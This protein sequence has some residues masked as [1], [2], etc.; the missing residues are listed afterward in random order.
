MEPEEVPRKYLIESERSSECIT[1]LYRGVETIVIQGDSLGEAQTIYLEGDRWDLTFEVQLAI[2][3]ATLFLTIRAYGDYEELTRWVELAKYDGLALACRCAD[4]VL[5]P[6]YLDKL[7][8][9]VQA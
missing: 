7:T 3:G 4:L 1:R 2:V 6:R 9:K 5:L 8:P